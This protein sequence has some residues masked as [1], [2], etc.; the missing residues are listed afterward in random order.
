ME[1]SLLES[2]H[3]SSSLIEERAHRDL[4]IIWAARERVI[5][6]F[7]FGPNAETVTTRAPTNG[8]MTNRSLNVGTRLQTFPDELIERLTGTPNPMERED[9][10]DDRR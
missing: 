3:I 2:D 7:V 1:T 6:Q 10:K 5:Q 8:I 4:I 9:R